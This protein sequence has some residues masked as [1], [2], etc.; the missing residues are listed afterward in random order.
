MRVAFYARVSSQ[1]QVQDQTIA[2]QLERL[3][4]HC[5]TQGWSWHSQ[6]IFRDEA[7][8]GAKLCRP[9][10]DRLRDQ[11][12]QAQFNR[13]LITAP[14]RLARKYLHQMLLLEE[15][16]KYGCQVEFLDRPMSKDPN[17]Q[18]LLQIRGA[19]S[20]YERVLIAERLRRGRLQFG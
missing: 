14:D 12:A 3:K 18:L 6:A 7:V 16:E 2:Q 5:E 19:V 9:A 10:L 11:I 8:S 4:N 1:Q 15:F 20:E 17:D 13:L